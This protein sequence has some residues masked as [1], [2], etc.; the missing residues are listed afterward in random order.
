MIADTQSAS[1]MPC[2]ERA[3]ADASVIASPTAKRQYGIWFESTSWDLGFR[4]A[5]D[6]AAQT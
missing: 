4:G 3:R 1:G 6:A 5:K 2:K